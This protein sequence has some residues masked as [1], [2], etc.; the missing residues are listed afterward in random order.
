MYYNA[1][2]LSDNII[3][4]LQEYRQSVKE[5]YGDDFIPAS[6]NLHLTFCY[7]GSTKLSDIQLESLKSDLETGLN[8]LS[9]EEK[10]ITFDDYDIFKSRYS[11]NFN[12]Y[13]MRVN[14]SDVLKRFRNMIYKKYNIQDRIS[15]Y[16][17]HITLGKLRK[18]SK[19]N[20]IPIPKEQGHITSIKYY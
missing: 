3:T 15:E 8:E 16:N 14:L 18:M 20:H 13:V 7:L 6:D 17:P 11:H 2:T 4:K 9:S 12:H 5:L 19:V 10:Q 1:L